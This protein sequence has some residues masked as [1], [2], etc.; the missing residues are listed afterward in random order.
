MAFF[1]INCWDKPGVLEERMKRRPAHL[2]YL[3]AHPDVIR[4]AG[5]QFDEQG[6]MNGSMF[7]V[8]FPD[9]AAVEAFAAGDPFS[10]YGVFGRVEIRGFTATM[11]S[12]LP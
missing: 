8:E 1:T 9:R 10:Q 6:Q 3:Q 12:W 7:V 4:I 2:A 5:P 11:G